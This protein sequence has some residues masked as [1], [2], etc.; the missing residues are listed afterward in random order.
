MV[1]LVLDSDLR[2][3]ITSKLVQT[4]TTAALQVWCLQ[5]AATSERA[6]ALVSRGV[7]VHEFGSRSESLPSLLTDLG[8]RRLT[9]LP[10]EPGPS[11]ARKGAIQPRKSSVH[12]QKEKLECFIASTLS[13]CGWPEREQAGRW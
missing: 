5:G 3:P 9:H 13:A 11:L 6:A 2:T 12:A 1:R 8:R 10:V 7:D 4:T